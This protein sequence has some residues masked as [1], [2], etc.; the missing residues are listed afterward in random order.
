MM[1]SSSGEGV[2]PARGAEASG[3]KC[4]RKRAA[5]REI[6][7]GEGRGAVAGRITTQ[8]WR[9]VSSS[10]PFLCQESW[11]HYHA[12]YIHHYNVFMEYVNGVNA[13]QTV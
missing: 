11:S 9:G 1:V 2:W 5:D 7:W 13:Q 12:V 4:G 3:L 8:R 6:R 10:C